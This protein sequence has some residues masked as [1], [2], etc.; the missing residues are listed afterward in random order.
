MLKKFLPEHAIVK[1]FGK[2]SDYAGTAQEK[3][4]ALAHDLKV[5][6]KEWEIKTIEGNQERGLDVVGWLPFQDGYANIVSVFGQCACGKEW[7][8]KQNETRRFNSSYYLFEKLDPIHAMFV[9]VALNRTTTFYQSD[10]VVNGTLLFERSRILEFIGDAGFFDGLKSKQI[11][12][13]CINY[14]EDLVG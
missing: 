6:I 1:Q 3:I 13:R 9:P 2:N 10:E 8:K 14:Q 4:I 11:V 7:Y 12:D 5:K